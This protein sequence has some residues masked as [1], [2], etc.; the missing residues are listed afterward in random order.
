MRTIIFISAIVVATAINPDS[1]NFEFSI[2]ISI[3]A[4]GAIILAIAGDIK[5]LLHR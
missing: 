2:S 5:D 1:V 3:F 4:I